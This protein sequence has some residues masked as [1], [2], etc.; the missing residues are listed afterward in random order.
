M[1]KG[2]VLHHYPTSWRKWISSAVD[3]LYV[4]VFM[5]LLAVLTSIALVAISNGPLKL[6]GDLALSLVVLAVTIAATGMDALKE[7]QVEQGKEKA[8]WVRRGFI[9]LLIFGG[10]LAAVSSPSEI[11][12]SDKINQ[13]V[14]TGFCALLLLAVL[15]LGFVAYTLGLKSRDAELER[16]YRLAFDRFDEDHEYLQRAE[17]REQ[18]LQEA[19]A[20]EQQGTYNGAKL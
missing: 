6:P 11:L 14:V 10:L 19:L 3:W 17:A 1:L 12:R 16:V 9:V 8:Q 18:R 7:Y 4:N 2:P 5:G 20:A 13:V 15:P